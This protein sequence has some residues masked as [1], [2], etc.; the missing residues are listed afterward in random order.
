[1][2]ESHL[3]QSYEFHGEP[4]LALS[5]RQAWKHMIELVESL[6]QLPLPLA[7]T[8]CQALGLVGISYPGGRRWVGATCKRGENDGN[9]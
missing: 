5:Y 1:M 6:Y 7:K 4:F 3:F 9:S 2:A 8:A